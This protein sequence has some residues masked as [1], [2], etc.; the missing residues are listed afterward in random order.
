MMDV[1]LHGSPVQCLAPKHP[2]KC[3]VVLQTNLGGKF[4]I[5]VH[6]ANELSA[7]NLGDYLVHGPAIEVFVGEN[8]ER[9]PVL[10]SVPL[11]R[12]Q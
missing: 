5:V 12:L 9:D 3:A 10:V 6:D 11:H 2:T 8:L 1:N 4:C 7:A